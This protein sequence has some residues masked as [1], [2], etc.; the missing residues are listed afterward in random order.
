R[1]TF[2]VA[3]FVTA[4][5]AAQAFWRQHAVIEFE[6]LP[7]EAETGKRA[8]WRLARHRPIWPAAA[9]FFLYN[10]L[11]GW[12]T[13]MFYHLT[14]TVGISSLLYGIFTAVQWSFFIPSAMLYAPLCRRFTLASLLWS[15][16]VIAILQGPIMFLAQGP[17]SA[18]GVAVL[19]G[20]FG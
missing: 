15:G 13:P 19:F 11:P 4:M 7:T 17:T 6:R 1:V 5:I 8:A 2:M 18:I 12:P 10:F 20:L 3:A 9:I 14:E 16:T